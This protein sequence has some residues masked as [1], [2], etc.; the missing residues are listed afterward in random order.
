MFT[1]KAIARINPRTHDKVKHLAV[2]QN[3]DICDIYD[4]AV[5]AL[6]LRYPELEECIKNI[7]NLK[8]SKDD[9]HPTS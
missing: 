7:Q 6:F 3:R 1:H 8:E 4:E 9:E 2:H 5:E